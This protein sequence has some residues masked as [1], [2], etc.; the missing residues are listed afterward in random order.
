MSGA[1]RD[2]LRPHVART[3]AA[4]RLRYATLQAQSITL[5]ADAQASVAHIGYDPGVTPY[6][7]LL[8]LVPDRFVDALALAGTAEEV[9][10]RVIILGRAGI[11]E[12]IVHPLAPTARGIDETIR[13]FAE[14]VTPAVR[15]ALAVV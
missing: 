11:R 9:T 8:P 6:L 15:G 12:V 7:H 5:P 14:V 1:A 10:E 4:G 2:V 3:L 13:S